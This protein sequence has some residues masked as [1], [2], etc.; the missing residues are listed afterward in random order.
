ME[1]KGWTI[2]ELADDS[3]QAVKEGFETITAGSIDALKAAIDAAEPDDANVTQH[4]GHWYT[5]AKG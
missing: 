5:R 2:T 3:Y 1:H 4:S